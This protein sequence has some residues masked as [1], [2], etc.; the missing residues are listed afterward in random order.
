[1]IWNE[2]VCLG[3]SITYGARDEYARSPTI[4]LSKIMK[5]K[6]GEVYICHNYAC[7]KPVSAVN[8]LQDIL[9]ESTRQKP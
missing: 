3:D 4:E 2:I 5:E 1:M 8:A 9:A 7:K 6:T